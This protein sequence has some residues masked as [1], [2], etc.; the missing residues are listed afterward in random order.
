M[1]LDLSRAIQGP[2][3]AC[4]AVGVE[5]K[6]SEPLGRNSLPELGRLYS[7]GLLVDQHSPNIRRALGIDERLVLFLW[8]EVLNVSTLCQ[9]VA[10]LPVA[11]GLTL[12]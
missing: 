6:G 4:G 5:M 8:R 12:E 9:S 1:R 7:G 2:A 3:Q 10:H 11:P